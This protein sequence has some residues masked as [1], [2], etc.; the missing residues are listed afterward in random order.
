MLTRPRLFPG[1]AFVMLLTLSTLVLSSCMSGSSYDVPPLPV[2]NAPPSRD[3][4]QLGTTSVYIDMKLRSATWRN[5]VN[6]MLA[7]QARR[8]YGSDT[9]AVIMLNYSESA[10]HGTGIAMAISYNPGPGM[11][12]ASQSSAQPAPSRPQSTPAAPA[13]G[14]SIA[15]EI[16]SAI[17]PSAGLPASP[18][19]ASSPP[20]PELGNQQ[21][22]YYY[23]RLSTAREEDAALSDEEVFGPFP[24]TPLLEC[25]LNDT[26]ISL[27]LFQRTPE[28]FA[29]INRQKQAGNT[30]GS[31][32]YEDY[33]VAMLEGECVN[34]MP[35]GR[36]V[37]G[38]SFVVNTVMTTNDT[39]YRFRTSSRLK[40]EGTMLNGA[41]EGE[42][43]VRQM[44]ETVHSSN[45][46]QDTQRSYRLGIH[47]DSVPVASHV[48][49]RYRQE[50]MQTRHTHI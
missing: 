40:I 45:L 6:Y 1:L 38:G 32:S 8:Q 4:R 17:T 21:A 10:R 5:T 34:G 19:V 9:H 42:V 11:I 25:Q 18:A 47:L 44:D 22:N 49:L 15:S 24:G 33:K 28:A 3:Y 41:L 14:S 43:F 12:S 48:S 50:G 13:A 46:P 26:A 36:F 30:Y 16:A 7:D 31:I 39:T 20:A 23:K 27:L 35:E 37:A 29:E 2:L